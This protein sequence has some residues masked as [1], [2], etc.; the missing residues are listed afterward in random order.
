V[1]G[2][3]RAVPSAVALLATLVSAS[4]YSYGPVP[5]P[6]PYGAA[7]RLRFHPA[8]SFTVVFG[9]LDTMR[10][11][12]VRR[13]EGYVVGA[14]GDTLQLELTGPKAVG[15]RRGTVAVVPEVGRPPQ[16]RRFSVLKA[17]GAV[18]AAAI[19]VTAGI[20]A[21]IAVAQSGG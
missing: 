3:R 21:G 5:A 10:L 7:V 4:C 19:V 6:V 20:L 13:L 9:G 11:R 16:L 18:L 2:H 8:R 12:N 1:F 17:T 15:Y 14:R